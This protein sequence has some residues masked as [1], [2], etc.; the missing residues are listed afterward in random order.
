[1]LGV[2]VL[3]VCA[4]CAQGAELD[5]RC[6]K[7]VCDD[8]LSKNECPD[9]DKD[10]VA[11]GRVFSYP[12]ECGCCDYCVTYLSP[13][14]PCDIGQPGQPTAS[15]V[16]GA[17]L[18]CLRDDGD[19]HAMCKRM[20]SECHDAQDAYDGSKDKGTLGHLQLRPAC[21][22]RGEFMPAQCIPGSI[23]YCVSP[24]GKRIF[25]EQ[26]FSSPDLVTS[27]ECACSRLV[28]FFIS[29]SRTS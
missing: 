23:C 8:W 19:E 10:C 2:A 9:L 22:E 21:D 27:M 16:C 12:I 1:M 3:L 26:P 14:E 15:K 4:L 17:G 20:R 5:L 7:S 25:G 6:S 29:F 11:N 18:T 28:L 24:T 13:G